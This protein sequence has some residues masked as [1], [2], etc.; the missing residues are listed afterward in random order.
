MTTPHPVYDVT[1]FE[2]CVTQETLVHFRKTLLQQ[3][4]ARLI[5][6]RSEARRPGWSQCHS[7]LGKI[8]RNV[9]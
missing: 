2:F 6:E 1:E 5:R 8:A 9:C 3:S 4:R 7:L